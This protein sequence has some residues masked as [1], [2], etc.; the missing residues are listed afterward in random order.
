MTTPTD[1]KYATTKPPLGVE[2]ARVDLLLDESH[3][4][5][6][7]SAVRNVLQ[8]EIAEITFAQII[9]GLPLKDVGLG[10]R[11]LHWETL[12]DHEKLCAGVLEKAKAFLGDFTPLQ[13]ELQVEA[14]RRYQKC[15]TDS[16]TSK[17]PLVELVVI[18]MHR[19]AMLL[20]KLDNPH[21]KDGTQMDTLCS[22]RGRAST[23][24]HPTPFCL[25]DYAD[26]AQYPEAV[27]DLPGYWAEDRIFGGVVLFGRGQDGTECKDVW[28]HSHRKGLTHRICALNDHQFDTL[29]HFLESPDIGDEN[30]CPLPI[31]VD[32]TNRRRVDE[33][34]AIP[35][36]NIYRD[37]WERK[38]R[39][40]DYEEFEWI[41]GGNCCLSE[42]DYPELEATRLYIQNYFKDVDT[43]ST[44]GSSPP[45][46]S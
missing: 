21:R 6:F 38:I 41:H 5:A 3:Q 19:I 1:P 39:F 7:Q 26:P 22:T 8:T 31:L 33:G 23:V 45:P 37:R 25:P 11:G 28:L 14:L 13:M 46:S 24:F 4:S 17:L 12:N 27:D 30:P 34:I 9:D 10:T 15:P 43:E 29:V 36:Y 2:K 16:S 32:K 42:A 44:D 35:E 20:H 40:S 18:A